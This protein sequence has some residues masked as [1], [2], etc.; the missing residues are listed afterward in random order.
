MS[1]LVVEF[2]AD[3]D[4]ILQTPDLMHIVAGAS[5]LPNST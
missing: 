3:E 5:I 2:V 1:I 4:E